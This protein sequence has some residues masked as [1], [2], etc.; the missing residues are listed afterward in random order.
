ML[1]MLKMAT[2]WTPYCFC[3]NHTSLL[4]LLQLHQA[5]FCLRTFDSPQYEKADPYAFTQLTVSLHLGLS[6]YSIHSEKSSLDT[7]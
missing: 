5:H 1:L 6:V 2:P 3:Y 7:T 4:S